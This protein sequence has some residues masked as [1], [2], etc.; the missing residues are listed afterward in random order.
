[1]P[2]NPALMSPQY[3]QIRRDEKGGTEPRVITIALGANLGFAGRAP[4]DAIHA[5]LARLA[6]R[7]VRAVKV[8]GYYA[9]PAWPAG[10]G[11]DFVN[12]VAVVETDL[13]P[14]RLLQTLLAVEREFGRTRTAR[15]EPRTLDLDIVDYNGVI[16]DTPGLRVPHP[17]LHE[18]AFVLVP[19]REVAPEWRHPLFGKT[20]AELLA[21]ISAAAQHD[22]RLLP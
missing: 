1:M 20:A 13:P 4:I 14:E 22:M 17:R 12:A 19:L 2:E 6:I 15:N 9:N 7:G 8:S 16:A 5:S 10:S 21:G 18:R 3:G 11:P